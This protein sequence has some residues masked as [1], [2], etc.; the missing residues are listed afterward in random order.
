MRVDQWTIYVWLPLLVAA[1]AKLFDEF[2]M[3][4]LLR[5]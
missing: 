4:F 5:E 2:S 1:S 3:V